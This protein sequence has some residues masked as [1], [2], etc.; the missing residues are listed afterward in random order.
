MSD[1]TNAPPGLRLLA[2]WLDKQQAEGR[3][4]DSK[5]YSCQ[6]DLRDW[7]D[8]IENLPKDHK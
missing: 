3:W 7:A 4:G 5:D 2:N 8:Q 1:L 6:S